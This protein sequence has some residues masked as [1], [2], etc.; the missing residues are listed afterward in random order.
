MD[1]DC[2]VKSTSQLNFLDS[3]LI[4]LIKELVYVFR[5]LN[6]LL[7]AVLSRVKYFSQMRQR[8]L[9]EQ[10]T[11]NCLQTDMKIKM[12]TTTVISNSLSCNQKSGSIRLQPITHDRS[13]FIDYFSVPRDTLTSKNIAIYRKHQ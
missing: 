10:E 5:E 13:S 4:P 2:V 8:E 9:A 11:S 1:P 7:E 12:T 3:I 6:V